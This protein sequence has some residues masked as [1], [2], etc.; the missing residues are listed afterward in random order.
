MS[1]P[2]PSPRGAETCVGNT[3]ELA[4][5]SDPAAKLIWDVSAE[6]Q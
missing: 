1:S 3:D 6:V 4:T 5:A 2:H